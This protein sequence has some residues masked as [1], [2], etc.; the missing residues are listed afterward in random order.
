MEKVISIRG[1]VS[2]LLFNTILYY[3][4]ERYLFGTDGQI[5]KAGEDCPKRVGIVVLGKRHYFEISKTFP[6]SSMKDINSAVRMD[7]S[8][9]APFQPERFFARK[10]SE[11]DG[12]ATLNIWFVD[13][14]LSDTLDALSPRL[15][16]P[17]S[18]LLPFADERA[19]KLFVIERGGE[20]LLVHAGPN[21]L[22]KSMT[23][24]KGDQALLS[25]RRT[26]GA[27]ARDCTVTVVKGIEEY[28]SLLRGI[29]ETM[30]LKRMLPFVNRDRFSLSGSKRN[31]KWSLGTAAALICL[32]ISLSFLFPYF[33]ATRLASED[34]A[35]SRNLGE[36]LKT[37]ED[38]EYYRNRGE[39]LARRINQYPYKIELVRD[40]NVLLPAKTKLKKLTVSGNMVEIRGATPKGSALLSALS[41]GRKSR[42]SSLRHGSGKTSKPAWSSFQFHLPMRVKGI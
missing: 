42:T 23:G 5:R 16:I 6:F 17:E 29:L 21:L 38:V 34:K 2:R 9:L 13:P 3:G 30:P 11:E 24:R 19:G 33:A 40:L 32:F 28:L 39:G 10:V 22:V 37:R 26:I 31:L 27:E 14:E 12:R 7:I 1:L 15:I 20:N 41:R 4:P 25:F 35:L 8:S 18:A 36:V